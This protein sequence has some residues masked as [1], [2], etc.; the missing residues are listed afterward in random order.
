[1]QIS[2]STIWKGKWYENIFSSSAIENWR[3]STWVFC[4]QVLIVEFDENL[5]G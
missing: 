4:F 2:Y 5:L 1:L 3:L